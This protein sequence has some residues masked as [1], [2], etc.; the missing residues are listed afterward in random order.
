MTSLSPAAAG[1]AQARHA[2]PGRPADFTLSFVYLKYSPP[3]LFHECLNTQKRSR[4]IRW[5]H[6]ITL[7]E[8]S[9]GIDA[10]L[11]LRTLYARSRKREGEV[12]LLVRTLETPR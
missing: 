7:Y 11:P 8:R 6:G 12:S 1:S 10:H 5:H 2:K 4:Q 9:S 3:V